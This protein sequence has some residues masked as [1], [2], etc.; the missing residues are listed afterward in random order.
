MKMKR[1]LKK[2][3]SLLL[4]VVMVLAMTA[5]AFADETET[6]PGSITINGISEENTYEIY[7]LLNLK[8][9]DTVVGT[10][11]YEVNESW[12]GF[13]ATDDIKAYID[14]VDGALKWVAGD[15]AEKVAE[16]SKKALV[17]AKAHGIQPVKSSKN[18]DDFVINDGA[19]VFSNLELGYYLID[20]TMGALCGLTTTNPNASIN[21]KNG[22]PEISK[23]VQEDSTGQW[24]DKNTADIGQTVSFRSTI[25]VHAGAQYY[26]VH[27]K[28]SP[29]LTFKRITKIEHIIPGTTSDPVSVDGEFYD[30]YTTDDL[31][32]EEIECKDECTFE[33]KFKNIFCDTLE[34]NDKI[35]IYY[36]AVLNENAIVAGDGNTNETWLDFGENHHTTHVTTKTY[37]Y[38]F[39]LVK[40]DGQNKLID[41][42]E[43]K[44]YD[45]ETDGNEIAVV[46]ISDVAYRRAK[47]GEKGVPIIVKN[48]QVRLSGFDNGTY[49]LEET[50][51]PDGYNGLSSRQKFIISDGNLDAVFNGDTFSTGSGVHVVNKSGTM[52]PETGGIGTTIFYILGGLM[53]FGA[54]VLMVTKKR[55]DSND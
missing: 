41:G 19:G 26:M 31:A 11:A 40:T 29:G 47:E 16:F 24:G 36:E 50:K 1:N 39:D 13:F 46:S 22:A 23:T 10:Y 3:A 52:L 30:V 21:A 32:T 48:G 9:Y 51:I 6:G 35:V 18:S 5:T 42:A 38:G 34:T 4:A 53:V 49:Y 7:K 55:M 14:V 17:Y 45:A 54:V 25:E 12:T 44:I 28:M 20:S 8:S 37:T 33:I 43:F 15:N 27:D 2:I